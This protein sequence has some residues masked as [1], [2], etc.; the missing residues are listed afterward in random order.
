[1]EER[2]WFLQNRLDRQLRIEGWN[3]AALDEARI[4]V[5]GDNDLLASLFILSASALGINDMVVVAPALD[6]LLV[7]IARK[8]N[9]LFTLTHMEG[10]YTHPV[11]DDLFEGCS[12]IVDLSHYGLANKLLFAKGFR[13]GVP[14]IRGFGYDQNGVRG[15]N[16][17]TYMRGREW[18]E[19]QRLVRPNNL[20]GRHPDDGV[21][22][23]IIA[24]IALEEAKSLLM[25]QRASKALISYERRRTGQIDDQS[26]V[27][28]VGSGALGTFVGLGLAYSGFKHC[29]FMDPDVVEVTNLNRQILLYDAFGQSKAET[30]STR[31]NDFFGMENRARAAYFQRDTDLSAYDVVFDCVDNFEARIVL[32]EECRDQGKTLISGGTSADA[33]QVVVYSPTKNGATPAELLGLYQIVSARNDEAPLRE[34]ASCTYRPDPSVIMTNQ[35]TAGFMVDSY[36]MLLDGQDVQNI[37]YDSTSSERI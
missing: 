1:V 4:G 24:G 13:D 3:Q 36:R 15:L 10:L 8:V 23:M 34:R 16:V 19:I 12:L 30:L 20:P 27:L 9:P 31:L 2:N 18:Q 29:T 35:I 11:L 22:D 17:F 25:T 14:V 7:E 26:R 6:G 28:V 37:F 33:G 21:L 5:V 32:S